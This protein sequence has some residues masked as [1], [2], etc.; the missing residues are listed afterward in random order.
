MP[1]PDW[2]A[3][4]LNYITDAYGA[5]F[6]GHSV[7][8]AMYRTLE[9]W[10]PTYIY[11]FN[12]QLGSQVLVVPKRYT[13]MPDNRTLTRGIECALLVATNST[14][15]PPERQGD[16]SYNTVWE[17]EVSAYVFGSGD[18]LQTQAITY[19]YAAAVRAAVVQ[20]K[21]LGD[22]ASTSHWT[23]EEYKYGE[24]SSTR[25]TGLAKVVF[26]VVVFG[27]VNDLLGP[28]LAEFAVQPSYAQPTLGVTP[29]QPEVETVGVTVTNTERES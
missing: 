3:W 2:S 10:L 23:H 26:D 15:G 17:A 28:P 16:G 29:M 12:R 21:S 27:A 8:E 25:Y 4:N 24:H 20:H 9:K 7:Q 1:Q 11:E 5:V 6:G 14:S 22:F 13:K 19:A 18:F